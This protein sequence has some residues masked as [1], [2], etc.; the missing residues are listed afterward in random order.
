[1]SANIEKLP[2]EI[3]TLLFEKVAADRDNPQRLQTLRSIA[4]TSKA[5]RSCVGRNSVWKEFVRTDELPFSVIDKKRLLGQPPVENTVH[6][7][8]KELLQQADRVSKLID[9]DAKR[10]SSKTYPLGDISKKF[11]DTKGHDSILFLSDVFSALRICSESQDV[12]A[13]QVCAREFIQLYKRKFT[14]YKKL[15]DHGLKKTTAESSVQVFKDSLKSYLMLY[16]TQFE[17][18]LSKKTEL[19]EE[20]FNMI[21]AEAQVLE[22]FL[23]VINPR[24]FINPLLVDIPEEFKDIPGAYLSLKELDSKKDVFI[25]DCTVW[26]EHTMDS[27]SEMQ[28]A[29]LSLYLMRKYNF[30]PDPKR[31][32]IL[33]KNLT[34][35]RLKC[36]E[37]DPRYI[38]FCRTHDP[39]FT[40]YQQKYE[41]L[42]LK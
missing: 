8:I 39:L 29:K 28:R 37:N 30:Y 31:V 35:S 33:Y 41:E 5:F 26:L 25:T 18:L 9:V 15:T 40:Y 12:A 21:G 42:Y 17:S 7:Q 2:T 36:S 34:V 13:L 19:L 11:T 1:M 32:Y 10:R 4:I 23:C 6:L 3:L 27:D 24:F 38:T 14:I 22:L 16:I 20:F